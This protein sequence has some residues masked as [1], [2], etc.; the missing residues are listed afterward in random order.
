MQD[1]TLQLRAKV[2]GREVFVDQYVVEKL[3]TARAIDF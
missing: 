1:R 2:K 3:A